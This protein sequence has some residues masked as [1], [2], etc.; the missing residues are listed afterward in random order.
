MAEQL[1]KAQI[2]YK[3]IKENHEDIV[4]YQGAFY[5]KLKGSTHWRTV[6][7]IDYLDIKYGEQLSYQ[8]LKWLEQ[9]LNSFDS[10]IVKKDSNK[11]P[12]RTQN[13]WDIFTVDN[14]IIVLEGIG[15]FTPYEIPIDYD[16]NATGENTDKFMASVVSEN[17]S[18]ENLYEILGEPLIRGPK[19]SSK[20]HL[21]WGGQGTGK[22]TFV[23][24]FFALYGDR[25]TTV[26]FK[27]IREG[28]RCH[29]LTYSLVNIDDDIDE[30][31]YGDTKMIKQIVT[32]DK[33][34]CDNLYKNTT[35]EIIPRFCNIFTCNDLPEFSSKGDEMSIRFRVEKF[36]NT[37]RGTD[38]CDID[39]PAKL[40]KELP[41]LLNKC[42]EGANRLLERNMKFNDTTDSNE[43]AEEVKRQD[44]V[45]S[46]L[47][48]YANVIE[49]NTAPETFELYTE[50]TKRD[51]KNPLS[52]HKFG[53]RMRAF[54]WETSTARDDNKEV[55]HY[56]RKNK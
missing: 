22:S 13:G 54:G 18:V 1:T 23:E 47:E 24:L 35:M 10:P 30:K 16:A 32:R 39:M 56:W 27:N 36:G 37:F 52:K 12:V 15:V 28:K 19:H 44:T 11:F 25:A 5:M 41:Y 4:L 3:K 31:Q 50:A 33:F 48:D 29:A 7:L 8:N 14:E 20:A 49:R 34:S 46:F 17:S 42:I 21:I 6:E 9:R 45:A 51:G 40:R 38:K 43:F 26:P 53:K 2:L 55:Y